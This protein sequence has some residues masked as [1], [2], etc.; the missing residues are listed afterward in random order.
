MSGSGTDK[1]KTGV[2]LAGPFPGEL[3]QDLVFTSALDLGELFA[4]N[5]IETFGEPVWIISQGPQVLRIL[6]DHPAR[7][8]LRK[9]IGPL[10]VDFHK[11]FKALLGRV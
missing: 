9:E 7:S 1:T 6:V 11:P 3:Q 8:E 5:V 10:K 2:E 4:D